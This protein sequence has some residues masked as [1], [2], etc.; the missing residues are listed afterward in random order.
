M[1]VRQATPSEEQDTKFG[2][3]VI[4]GN[5]GNKGIGFGEGDDLVALELG[6]KPGL[7]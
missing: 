2:F 5:N 4:I 7:A 6:V 3:R 1:A